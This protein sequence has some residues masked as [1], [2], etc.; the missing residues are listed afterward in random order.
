MNATFKSWIIANFEIIIFCL[1]FF[2]GVLFIAVY[3]MTLIIEYKD[4]FLY[5]AIIIATLTFPINNVGA[6]FLKYIIT[7]AINVFIAALAYLSPDEIV[8]SGAIIPCCCLFVG[9]SVFGGMMAHYTHLHFREVVS[10][11]MLY[12]N[13]KVNLFGIKWKYIL[14]RFSNISV[15][16]FICLLWLTVTIYF[17][18]NYEQYQIQ[19]NQIYG[20]Y[21]KYIMR[22]YLA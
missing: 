20:A 5:S 2:G 18:L 9:A 19:L 13:S 6:G 1:V 8:L 10:R 17:C 16:L 14:D 11:R 4:Y 22:H 12:H 15:S 3:D 21:E 7:L